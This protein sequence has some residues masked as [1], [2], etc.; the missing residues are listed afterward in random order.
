MKTVVSAVAVL[1]L[2]GCAAGHI[3]EQ[4]QLTNGNV[5]NSE[6]TFF[7]LATPTRLARGADGSM[8]YT[9][10]PQTEAVIGAFQAGVAAASGGLLGG[11]GGRPAMLQ[12]REPGPAVL[13]Q[14]GLPDGGTIT[15]TTTVTPD[16]EIDGEGPEKE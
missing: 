16:E 10:D 11:R 7:R 4:V 5:L 8:D 12:D 15:T 13:V 2:G 9:S 3:K 14:P 1:I 6:A